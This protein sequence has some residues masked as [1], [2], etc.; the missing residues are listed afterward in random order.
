MLKDRSSGIIFLMKNKFV[1]KIKSTISCD[2]KGCYL[3]LFLVGIVLVLFFVIPEF[4]SSKVYNEKSL[5]EEA[6]TREEEN[7]IDVLPFDKEAY[8]EKMEELANNPID[9]I[10]YKTIKTI[11]GKDKNGKDIIKTEKV[12]L[13]PKPVVSHLWPVK[14]PY[15]NK[16]AILPFNR[17]IAYYGNLYSKK[18]GVL[19]EYEENDMLQRLKTEV[20]K[21]ESADPT[22]PVIPALH[23]I[24]VVAQGSA[25]ADGK[26]RTR[27][28]D[29]EIDK[30]VE[31]AKKI[32]AI[33]FLDIQVGFSTL[34]EE[35]PKFEKYLKMSQV[36]LGV[37]PEFSMKGTIRPGKIVGTLDASDINFTVNYLS[38]VVKENNITPKILVV[39]RY[40]QK[41]VTNYKEIKPLSEVQIVMHMDGWGEKAKKIGTYKQFIYKEP[42]QFTGFKL[43]YKND[44]FTP[45]SVLLSP[46]ELLKLNPKPSYIQYQ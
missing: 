7:I 14:A 24:A 17:I 15:P 5:K 18:M 22:T 1:G 38:R 41:M 26:Y 42:V 11:T 20:E 46:E 34:Q 31:I 27:M 4:F 23:Y 9:P 2:S 10:V 21:W 35:V 6:I 45:G 44:L 28:P 3:F 43:F 16:G 13:D 8:D 19:G 40:T 30:V 36:H 29:S 25:G 37:D 39:H 32:N 33:V 12:P